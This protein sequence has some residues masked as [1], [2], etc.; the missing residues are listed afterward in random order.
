[1][2]CLPSLIS[3]FH[4]LTCLLADKAQA[5]PGKDLLFLFIWGLR[6]KPAVLFGPSFF[7]TPLLDLHEEF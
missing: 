5:I 2:H 3:R 1:M 6:L 4:K 7:Q